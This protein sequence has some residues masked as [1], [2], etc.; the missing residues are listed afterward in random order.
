MRG[1]LACRSIRL[2]DGTTGMNMKRCCFLQRGMRIPVSA[3][4]AS[5]K[6]SSAG[7][8]LPSDSMNMQDAILLL[9]CPAQDALAPTAASSG[10]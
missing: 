9:P 3:V 5:K 2:F 8:D 7:T 10:A 6:R 4:E 1:K